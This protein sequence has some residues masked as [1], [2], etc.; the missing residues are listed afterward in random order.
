MPSFLGQ[1]DQGIRP[2]TSG[3][4]RVYIHINPKPTQAILDYGLTQLGEVP[5][6]S[7]E[8]EQIKVP[9]R[10]SFNKWQNIGRIWQ[11]EEFQTT[12]FTTSANG[13]G[14]DDWEDLRKYQIEF[15]LYNTVG[16]VSDGN[17]LQADDA[18]NWTEKGVLPNCVVVS[19]TPFGESVNSKSENSEA[20]ASGTIQYDNGVIV[21]T[22]GFSPIGGAA[23]TVDMVD[24]FS[25]NQGEYTEF[26][27][28]TTNTVTTGPASMVVYGRTDKP[29]S[30][31]QNEITALA[32][33]G[34]LDRCYVSGN[35]MLA[36]R[37]ETGG[38]HAYASLDDIRAG[39]GGSAFTLVTSGYTVAKE[40]V[41]AAI[42]S[43]GNIILV[44]LGGYIYRLT[45]LTGTPTII[46]A[47]VLTTNNLNDVDFYNNQ[48]VAVGVSNTVLVS[49]EGGINSWVSVTG[50][51][52]GNALTAVQVVAVNQWYVGTDNGEVWFGDY[53]PV[54]NTATWTQINLFGATPTSIA[55]INFHEGIDK[56]LFGWIVGN[57]TNLFRTSSAGVRISNKS[58][59]FA[60]LSS[61]GFTTLAGVATVD[62]NECFVFGDVAGNSSIGLGS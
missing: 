54:A 52:A 44:A 61:V 13:A 49:D 15:A 38:G 14:K 23:L 37:G 10:K 7:P 4:Q 41:A 8:P 21:R 56:R 43:E 28:V 22:V 1:R 19:V 17:S 34:L 46:D 11:P 35:A 53:D 59:E 57:G 31:T 29:N 36:T 5:F 20:M 16:A 3:M 62:E 27:G 51:S 2:F 39:N 25:L 9:D 45:N 6:A 60:R 18:H 50:P 55:R 32:T 26:F 42:I 47:G 24:G 58:P 48:V 33:D 12:D 40:P 30:F